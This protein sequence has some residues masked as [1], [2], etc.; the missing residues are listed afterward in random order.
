MIKDRNY[1]SWT[2]CDGLVCA[3]WKSRR[4]SLPFIMARRLHKLCKLNFP[5]AELVSLKRSTYVGKEK[6]AWWTAKWKV[7]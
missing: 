3:K 2:D 4:W 6:L 1:H 7:K 5:N